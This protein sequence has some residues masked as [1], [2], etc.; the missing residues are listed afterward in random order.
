MEALE[1]FKEEHRKLEEHKYV[2]QAAGKQVATPPGVESTPAFGALMSGR[3]A[4]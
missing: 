1:L 2:C 4:E 3:E